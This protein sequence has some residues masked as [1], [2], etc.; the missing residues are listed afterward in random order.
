MKDSQKLSKS[1]DRGYMRTSEAGNNGAGSRK[2]GMAKRQ[3]AHD[4]ASL[5]S[6]NTSPT[7]QHLA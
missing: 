1:I 4:M 3:S 6:K 7:N 2:F 5:G